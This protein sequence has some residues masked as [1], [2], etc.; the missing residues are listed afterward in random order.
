[1]SLA[2]RIART[3]W[4]GCTPN[5]MPDAAWELVD[6]AVQIPMVG[7]GSSLNVAVAGSLVQVV[8]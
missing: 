2:C 1:M 7:R 4:R 8:S 6:E 5:A 3:C